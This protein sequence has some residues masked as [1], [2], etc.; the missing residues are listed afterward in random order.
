MSKKNIEKIVGAAYEELG[1]EDM[2]QIQGAGDVD[3][4]TAV[5]VIVAVATAASAIYSSQKC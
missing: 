5:P 4:E 1:A 3:A 2:Q